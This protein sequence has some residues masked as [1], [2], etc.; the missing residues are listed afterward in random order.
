[1]MK[2]SIF[3]LLA[4]TL[5]SCTEQTDTD[6]AL[7]VIST[8]GLASYVEVLGSDEFMGRAP[9]S[10]GEELTVNYLEE[11]LKHIGFDPAF[12][13]S[14]RQSVPMVSITSHLDGPALIKTAN[15]SFSFHEGI[16]N[17]GFKGISIDLDRRRDYN[18]PHLRVYFFALHYVRRHF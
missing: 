9:F 8:D 15:R 12:G 1:M 16:R 7:S 2:K 13:D 18:H 6:N 10:E 14:Y 11:Q 4:L 17:P 5:F 3:L